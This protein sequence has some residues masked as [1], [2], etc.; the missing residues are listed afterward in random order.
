MPTTK[1]MMIAELYSAQVTMSMK[2]R[3]TSIQAVIDASEPANC[4]HTKVS[5][6]YLVDTALFALRQKPEAE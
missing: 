1:F 6:I 4:K 2:A 3:L 5:V